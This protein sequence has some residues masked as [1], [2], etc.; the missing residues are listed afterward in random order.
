VALAFCVWRREEI[1]AWW[2]TRAAR[3]GSAAGVRRALRCGGDPNARSLGW[4][5]VQAAEGAPA[6]SVQL[7]EPALLL[8]AAEGH[9]AVLRVLLEAGADP[10]LPDLAGRTPLGVAVAGGHEEAAALLREA[11]GQEQPPEAPGG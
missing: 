9:V 10:N 6:Q 1:L 8:A 3:T 4:T 7:W 2:L 11:G 5:E